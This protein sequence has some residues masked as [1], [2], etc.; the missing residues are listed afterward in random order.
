MFDLHLWP[1]CKTANEQTENISWCVKLF[2][3]DTLALCKDTDKE[4]KEKKLKESWETAEPGRAEKATAS[5]RRYQL[6]MKQKKGEKLS[7]E[8]L[9]FLAEKRERVKKA[10]M[11]EIAAPGKAG[12]GGKAPA[13]A[14]AKAAKPDKD[15]DDADK[16]KEDEAAKRVL[17]EPKEH[18]NREIVQFLNHFKSKRLIKVICKDPTTDRRKRSDEE[19]GEMAAAI[20]TRT[21]KEKETHENYL[22]FSETL[23]EK[24]EEYRKVV[25]DLVIK[26][27]DDYKTILVGEM[28]NRNKYRELINNRKDK[29]KALTELLAQEK[30][31]LASLQTAIDQAVEAIV[32]DELIQKA[33]KQ[34]D[35]LKYCKEVEGQLQAAVAEKVKENLAAVLEKIEK[36]GVLIEPKMLNDA[37]NVLNKMK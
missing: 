35:W 26:G 31:D 7:E 33:N 2:N 27:R 28:E 34:L 30:I 4:D 17:P 13:K 18:I 1:D 20:V 22:K 8:D 14:P 5:R 6:Q 3:S 36:E 11:A 16:K 19:K 29:E 15:K 24:R 32:K 9:E 10:D 25:G 23:S 12:K 37:K 21:E